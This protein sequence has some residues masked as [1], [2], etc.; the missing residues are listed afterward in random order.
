M[1]A[2]TRNS[3]NEIELNEPFFIVVLTMSK[4]D[5][6]ASIDCVVVLG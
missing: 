3:K 5:T 1:L 2:D 4:D 6:N